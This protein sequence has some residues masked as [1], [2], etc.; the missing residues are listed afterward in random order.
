[1]NVKI[2]AGEENFVFGIAKNMTIR[3]KIELVLVSILFYIIMGGIAA[4]VPIVVI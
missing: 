2:K 3:D 1:M 4:N